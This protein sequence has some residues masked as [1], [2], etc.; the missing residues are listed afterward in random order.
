MVFGW[1]LDKV[2]PIG[3]EMVFL[4]QPR[5]SGLMCGYDINEKG[6]IALSVKYVGSKPNRKTGYVFLPEDFSPAINSIDFSSYLGIIVCWK[7]PDG[8]STFMPPELQQKNTELFSLKK[9]NDI[10]K[11]KIIEFLNV[12]ESKDIRESRRIETIEGAKELKA[13]KDIV[14]EKEIVSDSRSPGFSRSMFSR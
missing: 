6:M 7:N 9:L 10:H 1:A 14:A 13:L 11:R 8:K 2:L 3:V 5:E 4:G 12:L